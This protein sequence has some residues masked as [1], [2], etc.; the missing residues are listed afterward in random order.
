MKSFVFNNI[1]FLLGESAIENWQL[2]DNLKTHHNNSSDNS[3]DKQNYIWFHLHN[4][5]SPYVIMKSSDINNKQN[6]YYGA[7]L[8]K[9]YSKYKNI[10]VNVIYTSIK[11][12]KKTQKIGEVIVK[13]KFNKIL[14]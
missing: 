8:C 11:N 1:T 4:L 5:T 6:I 7:N 12:I 14:L 13:N 9:E 2:L 10:P 3:T